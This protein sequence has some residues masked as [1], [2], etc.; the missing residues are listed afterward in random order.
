M[1]FLPTTHPS[2]AR[3]GEKDVS[4]ATNLLEAE[5]RKNGGSVHV[6]TKWDNNLERMKEAVMLH[7]WEG[8]RHGQ[9]TELAL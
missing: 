8:M 7:S 5:I 4:A 1:E 9:P 2:L 3:L 6:L